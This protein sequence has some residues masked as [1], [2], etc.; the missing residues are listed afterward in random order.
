M[1]FFCVSFE[2]N[3]KDTYVTCCSIYSNK[4]PDFVSFCSQ[5]NHDVLLSIAHKQR[6]LVAT[7]T[8]TCGL[9]KKQQL[10]F[11]NRKHHEANLIYIL[12]LMRH[13]RTNSTH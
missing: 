7:I 11:F 10:I 4:A 3:L 12:Y 1:G 2:F 9:K 5:R 8:L 13:F 6:H